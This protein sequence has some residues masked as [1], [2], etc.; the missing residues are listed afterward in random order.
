VSE[1]KTTETPMNLTD[2]KTKS[3]Q[4]LIDIAREH[5]PR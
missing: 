4:E 5:R 1:D 2:L 3:T